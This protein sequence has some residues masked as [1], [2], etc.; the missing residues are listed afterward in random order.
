M[1]A[2]GTPTLGP[3]VSERGLCEAYQSLYLSIYLKLAREDR[4]EIDE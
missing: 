2:P 3:H 1:V 4:E